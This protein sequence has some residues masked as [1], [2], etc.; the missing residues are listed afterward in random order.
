MADRIDAVPVATLEASR[1]RWRS[2]RTA[3]A[4]TQSLEKHA[5]PKNGT[6]PVERVGQYEMLRILE[7]L[8]STRP[9]LARKLRQ[10]I[11]TTLK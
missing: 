9:Q 10:R 6:L 2:A 1:A 8:S 5:F 11:R 3:R 7:P 4:W